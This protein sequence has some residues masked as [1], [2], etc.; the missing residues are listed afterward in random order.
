MRRRGYLILVGM[1]GVGVVA[2]SG[3][4]VLQRA[5]TANHARV[6]PVPAGDQEVAWIAPATSGDSWERLVAALEVLVERWPKEAAAAAPSI[7]IARAF[8]D[9]T[10]DVPE[11]SVSFGAGKLWIRWYKL[12]G[13]ADSRQWIAHLLARGRPPLMVIGGDTSDRALALAQALHAR[14]DQWPGPAPLFLITTATAERYVPKDRTGGLASYDQWPLL[15]DVYPGRTFRFA[16]TNTRMVQA[17]LDFVQNTPQV[18]PQK[19]HDPAFLAGVVAGADAWHS[20]ALLIAGGH[21]QPYYLYTL[22]WGDDGYSLDLREAFSRQFTQSLRSSQGQ[23]EFIKFDDAPIPYGAGDPYQP[24]PREHLA[25]TAFLAN[26][27]VLRDRQH[28]LVLPT[29][30]QRARRFL[31]TLCQRAPLEMRN[32]VVVNGDAISFNTIYR[33]RAVAWNILDVPVPLVF[34]S[35]RNPTDHTAGFEPH[36]AATGTQDLLLYL[37]LLQAV[38]Y[39]CFRQERIVTD[40]DE[41][42]ERLRRLRWHSGRLLPPTDA[43]GGHETLFFTAE[44]NRSARTGEHVV[45]LRPAFEATRNLPRATITVWRLG[46]SGWQLAE[47]PLEVDYFRS[48]LE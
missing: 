38:V 28:L 17:V 42:G 14:A 35:H 45:W 24:N 5:V 12:S 4:L 7:E 3:V 41:V 18:W 47:P 43:P 29:G 21:W 27:G 32:V 40:A 15:M 37:D 23:E 11:I 9:L 16:F 44:G 39:G 33:D 36:A 48:N 13:E 10:A 26:R 30:A 34:F 22:A 6:R 19:N 2:G 8:L 20:L 46:D 31:R 1:I 25:A